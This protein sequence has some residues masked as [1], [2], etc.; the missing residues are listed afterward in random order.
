ML[1]E[2]HNFSYV[3]KWDHG[4]WGSDFPIG[5]GCFLRG[6]LLSYSDCW[7]GL[8]SLMV[9]RLKEK[10]RTLPSTPWILSGSWLINHLGKLACGTPW[11]AHEQVKC[12]AHSFPISLVTSSQRRYH[13]SICH[14]KSK[15]KRILKA[16]K[17]S[18]A[19]HVLGNLFKSISKYLSSMMIYLI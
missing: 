7:G 13:H 15:T 9:R 12:P 6:L 11:L 8:P 1:Y 18:K 5:V 17:K 2:A 16:I 10:L 14:Q 4:E 19:W 3:G